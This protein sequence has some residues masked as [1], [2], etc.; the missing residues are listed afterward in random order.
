MLRRRSSSFLLIVFL[1]FVVV[2]E[3]APD[4]S[5]LPSIEK[6]ES[7]AENARVI[8]PGRESATRHAM[9]A[10]GLMEGARRSRLT[11]G[12]AAGKD[13][14]Y[15]A[16]ED[17]DMLAAGAESARDAGPVDP[18][19]R[20]RLAA[21]T[22]L[23]DRDGAASAPDKLS[24]GGRD[25]PWTT[26]RLLADATHMDDAYVSIA[27]SPIS[28]NLYAV[29]EA[30]D[31]GG[32]DRD[33]H[34][35]RSTD[36]GLNWSVWEM[37]S[38]SQ[39]EYH[40]ELAID[41]QGYLF[42]AWIRED[43]YIL[44]S[45]TENPDDPTL[46]S[47]VK[48]L[49]VGETCATTA[50]DA[51]WGGSN[52]RVFIAA[53]WYTINYDLYA[54][55]WTLIWMYSDDGGE[56][57]EFD[58]FLPDG[59]NDYWPD[60]AI[61]N[62]DVWFINA[63]QD[64]Y[65]GEVEILVA[66]DQ[67]DGGFINPMS[68]S[69]WTINDCR[70][71]AITNAGDDVFMVFQHDY[72]DFQGTADGDVVYCVSW[73]GLANVYGPYDMV[74]DE[75]ESVGPAIYAKDG[76]VGCLWFDAPPGGDEFYIVAR[77]AGGDGHPDLWGQIEQAS[78]HP[79]ADPVFHNAYGVKD[80]ALLRAAWIDRR[81][82][83]TQGLNVYT[84][85][86]P[87]E[88]NLA[89]FV[90]DGWEAP[91]VANW[92][93]GEKTNGPLA[94]GDTNFVSFAFINNGLTDI[95][96]D[97][98]VRLLLDG[99]E[100]AAWVLSGGL[101][102]TTYVAVE[103]HPVFLGAG[104]HAIGFE[105]DVLAEVDESDETDNVFA[106][107]FTTVTGAPSLRFH[108][109]AVTVFLDEPAPAR[110]EALRI[111]AEA[112][113]ERITYMQT[114]D[115]RLDAALGKAAARERLP[116]MIVPA[117][118]V[119]AQALG[120]LLRGASPDD[121]RDAVRAAL[122]DESRA[123]RALLAPSW[124][125]SVREGHMSEPRERWLLG[126]FRAEMDAEAIRRLAGS[127]DVA[128]LWLD[129]RLSQTFAASASEPAD[130]LAAPGVPAPPATTGA[131]ALAWHLPKIGADDAWTAGYDGSG[132]LVGHLDTGVAYDHPDLAGQMWNGGASYPH[133]GWDAADDDND[134]YDGDSPDYHGTHT[135]GLVVGDGTMGTA[136]GAAPGATIMA[137]RCVPGSYDDLVESLE[138]G[139]EHGA[140][141]FT[142]SAGWMQAPEDVREA[143]RHNAEV[144]QAA[145]ILWIAAAGNGDNVGGHYAA[146][147]DIADPGDCPNPYYGAAGRSGVIT[148]GATTSMNGVYAYSSYGPT[149]WDFTTA[150]S[151][152]DDYPWPPGL[153]KPDIAAP[154]VNVTSTTPPNTYI[155]YEGTSMA[156]PLVAG[157]CAI[158]LQAAPASM[159][160]EIAEAIETGALDLTASPASPGRDNYTGAG[161]LDIPASLDGLPTATTEFIYVCNDGALPLVVDTVSWNAAWLTVSPAAGGRVDPGDSLRFA[162]RIEPAG[163]GYGV[164]ADEAL[165]AGNDPA[166]PRALPVTLVIGDAT[167][168]G[169]SPAPR[170]P[171]A[172]LRNTPNPFNPRTVIRFDNPVR[173][174]VRLTLYTASGR[175]V[176]RLVDGTMDA[177]SHE[178]VWDGRDD[179]GRSLASG[180]Y[181][182]RLETAEGE[183]RARKMTLVR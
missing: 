114:I 7:G 50:I 73:D 78:E 172:S 147:Y 81:D 129:D 24:R 57:V 122:H 86:R 168:V 155:A 136:T 151:E 110:D 102:I 87:T 173:G 44:R 66:A 156:T 2:G 99:D 142:F 36:G 70:F 35:A 18:A 94:A 126:A 154:G 164:H 180:V 106:D 42:V 158:L 16:F 41:T 46:W 131:R 182:A 128:R 83:P 112:P 9:P 56:T 119:D 15:P 125:R 101:P 13:A 55:E 152:Y 38:F 59:Y 113:V 144:L 40:P 109:D 52:A 178:A 157:A 65:T 74:A 28:G 31:L 4:A 176:R 11:F 39:D 146:P 166:S 89:P 64:Y 22:R 3:A 79:Y 165:F 120:A 169:G 34:I 138:F 67:M 27:A 5:S 77:Q 8:A 80:D 139:F 116:V 160:E 117:E 133:H 62:R 115:P 174:R 127:P 76:V 54:Y 6:R 91:L 47:W 90:P 71:P 104:P 49:N 26:D 98:R 25:L 23:T 61:K 105:L 100:E 145:G 12:S 135:A 167:R 179:G 63:E 170:P 121:R 132:I 92:I 161:L 58:Y 72:D 143:S 108:P 21:L 17:V 53:A 75:Y 69:D 45:R 30:T 95:T 20:E 37:P 51:A 137:L 159:P 171:S 153:M 123:T 68:L 32:T 10:P 140:Q 124:D 84:C 103:D 141:L 181:L 111:A 150:E 118:R 85:E 48:G 130:A 60:V 134:P 107:T 82:Y 93:P 175:E 43:G 162:C 29:F 1:L 88:A 96:A 177:G 14:R 149:E 183:T 163:L 97:F 33:I 148:V 19:T